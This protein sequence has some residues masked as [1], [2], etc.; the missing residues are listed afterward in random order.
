MALKILLVFIIGLLAGWLI[1]WVIDWVYWR[2]PKKT[3][4][5]SQYQSRFQKASSKSLEKTQLGSRLETLA[6]TNPALG[7]VMATMLSRP[8]MIDKTPEVMAT[9]LHAD[10]ANWF[11]DVMDRSSG[12]YKRKARKWAWL[13]GTLLAFALNVDSIEI[14][15]RLWREPTVRQ[16][17]VAQAQSYQDSGEMTSSNE[18]MDQVNQ[19]GIPVGWTTALPM[20]GQQCGWTPGQAVYP[21][22]WSNQ[23]CKIL[24]NLPRMDD[25]WGWLL[26][27]FGL[28]ISG[29]AAA[30]GA[31]FWFDMLNKVFNLRSSGK[32]PRSSRGVPAGTQE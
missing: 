5:P 2:K 6:T 12:D 20:D 11:D 17:I 27:I 9:Q 21:A 16:V 7:D 4:A 8:D 24:I 28:L 14:A 1:E 23:T 29:I 18:I 26:K 22:I 19:L 3:A 31:P 13:L 15:T 25:G 30:Q 10:L 32:V